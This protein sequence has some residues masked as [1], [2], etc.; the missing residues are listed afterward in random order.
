MGLEAKQSG[1][2]GLPLVRS[3]YEPEIPPFLKVRKKE[4]I[5]FLS[6][7]M[8]NTHLH[9][10]SGSFSFVLG[11]LVTILFANDTSEVVAIVS[12]ALSLAGCI[13][14][15]ENHSN[16]FWD[17]AFFP[18]PHTLDRQFSALLRQLLRIGLV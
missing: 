5:S 7:C 12:I 4:R 1:L 14:F 9:R 3:K 6:S 2:Q 10:H 17:L 8:I 11:P 18:I 13:P 16:P 15:F